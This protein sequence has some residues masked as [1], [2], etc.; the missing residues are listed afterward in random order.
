[1]QHQTVFTL[2]GS[3]FTLSNNKI[4]AF[5]QLQYDESVDMLQQIQTSAFAIQCYKSTRNDF[6]IDQ[7]KGFTIFQS[8]NVVF[9]Q[10]SIEI[11]NDGIFGFILDDFTYLYQNIIQINDKIYKISF[12]VLTEVPEIKI[13][14]IHILR[15][16][17]QLFA[18]LETI[19]VES[20]PGNRNMLTIQTGELV[21]QFFANDIIKLFVFQSQIFAC[22]VGAVY[23]MTYNSFDEIYQ[24]NFQLYESDNHLYLISTGADLH[25]FQGGQFIRLGIRG[26]GHQLDTNIYAHQIDHQLCLSQMD[27]SVQGR[28]QYDVSISR[29]QFRRLSARTVV[30][31]NYI[32]RFNDDSMFVMQQYK[33]PSTER[34]IAIEGRDAVLRCGSYTVSK[35]ELDISIKQL[36][37]EGR[38]LLMNADLQLVLV[39]EIDD[40]L[41]VTK[42][43][44][45]QM[46]PSAFYIAESSGG[47]DVFIGCK[48]GEILQVRLSQMRNLTDIKFIST[49]SDFAVHLSVV[50]GM[51][52]CLSV[53][54]SIRS[55][56]LQ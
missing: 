47:L 33:M 18:Q 32:M 23:I 40:V 44:L 55:Y 56:S 35:T 20:V 43:R 30:V 52:Y 24:G 7:I 37:S 6:L 11:F 54:G 4:N 29:K 28:W 8:M 12:E 48:T 25:Q 22:S 15:S 1:M 14:L 34:S 5:S 16:I 42:L 17:D 38:V 53:L 31:N 2:N 9:Y 46:I 49:D 26:E 41:M 50:G 21:N 36:H 27:A 51:L 3:I 39:E 19:K 13:D 45:P 10:K